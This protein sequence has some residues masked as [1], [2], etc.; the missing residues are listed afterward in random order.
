MTFRDQTK[1]VL[2]LDTGDTFDLDY[3]LDEHKFHSILVS[4]KARVCPLCVGLIIP[5]AELSGLVVSTRLQRRIAN[6]YSP[7][8]SAAITLGDSTCVISSMDK[9]ATS[10]S[11]FFHAWVSDGLI[12]RE[13]IGQKVA[14]NKEIHHV[15]SENLL[16]ILVVTS[17]LIVHLDK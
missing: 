16:L 3:N 4:A 7:G 8:L 15:S 13:K 14:L 6:N 12:N 5:Q 2:S 17:M 1:S 10:F 11:P 9:K